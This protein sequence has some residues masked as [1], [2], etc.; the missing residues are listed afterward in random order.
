MTSPKKDAEVRQHLRDAVFHLLCCW[1]S[2]NAAERADGGVIEVGDIECIAGGLLMKDDALAADDATVQRWLDE[3]RHE[4][5][6]RCMS[7]D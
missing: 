2:L 4:R 7:D 3:I 6:E 1:D 5:N